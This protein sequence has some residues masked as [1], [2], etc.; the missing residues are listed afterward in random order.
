MV[1]PMRLTRRGFA[2]GGAAFALGAV[3][4]V[5]VGNTESAP[6]TTPL[7]I[8]QF[9]DAAKQGNAVTLKAMAGRHAFIKDSGY[10]P[11]SIAAPQSHV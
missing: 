8:P 7:P 6:F 2:L 5:R 4:C 10:G 9:I 11:L 1:K 3:P